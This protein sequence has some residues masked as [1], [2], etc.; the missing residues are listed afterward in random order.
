MFLAGEN[1]QRV[2]AK[3]IA[4]ANA[5][6]ESKKSPAE[7]FAELKNLLSNVREE[8]VNVP[9][10][11]LEDWLRYR[12][13][14]IFCEV[15]E[16][17]KTSSFAHFKEKF[18]DFIKKIRNIKSTDK[19]EKYE[20]FEG[21][22]SLDG[23]GVVDD[24]KR[25]NLETILRLDNDGTWKALFDEFI[26]IQALSIFEQQFNVDNAERQKEGLPER[27]KSAE[28]YLTYLDDPS[29]HNGV[30]LDKILKD[31]VVAKKDTGLMDNNM[32]Y[33]ERVP[34]TV[35]YMGALKKDGR[36]I[37][38]TEV[39]RNTRGVNERKVVLA[40]IEK[41]QNTATRIVKSLLRHRIECFG[42]SE[43]YVSKFSLKQRIAANSDISSEVVAGETIEEA[44]KPLSFDAFYKKRT[45]K[46]WNPDIVSQ[47]AEEGTKGAILVSSESNN[48]QSEQEDQV[49]P[50]RP[51][52]K[53]LTGA[54]I[55]G[56]IGAVVGAVIG[57][58]FSLVAAAAIA[59]TAGIGI[60]VGAVFGWFAHKLG[61]CCHRSAK[62]PDS[63]PINSKPE[64][65]SA[66][67]SPR[68]R[69]QQLD[70]LYRLRKASESAV[71]IKPPCTSPTADVVSENIVTAE[72]TIPLKLSPKT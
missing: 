32:P 10:L 40:D 15:C 24:K 42:I 70:T 4:E 59:V 58:P 26:Y 14:R 25:D 19:K 72:I 57:A 30:A 2:E 54:L 39:L 62:E 43:I 55:F 28:V 44:Y 16:I 7:Q 51:W 71:P 22:T 60:V 61:E 33:V 27:K 31:E 3:Y 20:D 65:S 29:Y 13:L 53:M 63:I 45:G 21:I 11:E 18:E 48:D 1:M 69:Q 5:L 37:L 64:E 46:E 36:G 35:S 49:K 41:S 9:L 6:L 66:P 68:A 52:K 47:K 8:N 12:M 56:V 23:R 67:G 34:G 38:L 17:D 50:S